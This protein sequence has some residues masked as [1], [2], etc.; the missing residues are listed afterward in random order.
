MLWEYEISIPVFWVQKLKCKH[1]SCKPEIGLYP[2]PMK[3]SILILSPLLFTIAILN[4]LLRRNHLLMSLLSLEVIILG[5][6]LILV[7]AKLSS[8]GP[9][10]PEMVCLLILL[11][12]G[13][14]EASLGLA[15]LVLMTRSYGNDR[16]NSLTNAKC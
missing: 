16:L 3:Y 4:I 14:C 13:A 9:F 11:T 15:C 10:P 8:T 6:L 5:L 1:W 12:M 7:A 2:E